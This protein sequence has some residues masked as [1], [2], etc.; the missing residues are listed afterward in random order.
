M[1]DIRFYHMQK[2]TLDDVLPLL[3]EKAYKAGHKAV[4]KFEN[5][6]EVERFDTLL[7]TYRQSGFL[8]HGSKKDGQ[9]E[10]QPI[11]L[12]DSEENPNNADMLVL[13]QGQSSQGIEDY[14][15][16]CE[17]LDGRSAEQVSA[18]RARW[19]EYQAAGHTVTYWF[20][21][22]SGGWEKKA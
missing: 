8:P 7:W 13:A 22:E 1:T 3:L 21:G 10:R 12:T 6:A 14:A 17:M 18:A 9:A 16:C 11:W 20:Q 2:Q 19:K 5:T 4:I 15:L